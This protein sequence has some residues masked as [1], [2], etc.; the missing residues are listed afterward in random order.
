MMTFRHLVFLLIGKTEVELTK[1][2]FADA[3][4]VLPERMI[5][6][7]NLSSPNFFGVKIKLK[8]ELK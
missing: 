7:M 4:S 5:D 1:E 3:F 2:E 6:K 8:E